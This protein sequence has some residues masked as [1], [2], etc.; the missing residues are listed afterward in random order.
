MGKKVKISPKNLFREPIILITVVIGFIFLANV[1]LTAPSTVQNHNTPVI[2]KVHRGASLDAISEILLNEGLI[3][4]KFYFKLVAKIK[5]WENSLQAGSYLISPGEGPLEILEKM[6]NGDAVIDTVHF[7]IPE[8]YTVEQIAQVIEGKNLARKEEFLDAVKK[9]KLEGLEASGGEYPLEGYL[10]PDTYEVYADAQPDEIISLMLKRFFQVV[11]QEYLARLDAAGM[12]LKDAVTLASVVEREAVV[13]E[14][15]PII[16]AVFLK[17]LEIGMPLQSCATINYL[18]PEPKDHLTDKE[19]A[20]DSP[21]NTYK[22]K[23]LPPGPI[24]NPGKASLDAVINPDDQGYLYF[25]AKNDG[26]HAFG[27]TLQEHNQNRR[28]YQ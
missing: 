12:S 22:Y 16:A 24:G 5:G 17:R 28:R 25:V 23:G 4:N 14:E 11:D 21:Y 2:V 19:L 9:F 7:T 20:I 26:T 8:G 6:K 1:F 3:G 27:R 15:R 10:F 18:L 13:D